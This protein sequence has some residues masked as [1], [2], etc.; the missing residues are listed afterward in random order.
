MGEYSYN[1]MFTIKYDFG[2]PVDE[3]D[4]ENNQAYHLI[5]NMLIS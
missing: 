4:F 2:H 5:Q 3:A 1:H